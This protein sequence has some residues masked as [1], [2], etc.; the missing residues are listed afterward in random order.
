MEL[1]F[2]FPQHKEL[3]LF[4]LP[5][6]VSF[7]F[8]SLTKLSN[9]QISVQLQKEFYY[10]QKRFWLKYRSDDQNASHAIVSMVK[11]WEKRWLD[12]KVKLILTDHWPDQQ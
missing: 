12:A 9:I 8:F 2:L 10:E 3:L 4:D 7:P 1:S 5:R 11:S 6:M